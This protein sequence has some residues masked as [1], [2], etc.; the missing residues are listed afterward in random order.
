MKLHTLQLL[1]QKRFAD[2]IDALTK[3]IKADRYDAGL[4]Q[5]RSEAYFETGR[6]DLAV[7]DLRTANELSLHDPDYGD[8]Y[9]YQEYLATVLWI[10]GDRQEAIN[11]LYEKAEATLPKKV[12][13]V[14]MGGGVEPGLF[15]FY[16]SV[17][18]EAKRMDEYALNYVEKM[19]KRDPGV[20][21][22]PR[23]LAFF[24]LG[25]WS[26]SDLLRQQSEQAKSFDIK[27]DE[28]LSK[29]N[30]CDFLF[31]KATLARRA[32]DESA[33]QSLMK[34]CAALDVNKWW[35]EWLLARAETGLIGA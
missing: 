17:S 9:F 34:Q 20:M 1:E 3:E 26:E 4:H 8:K 11:A 29:Y 23:P 19:I 2:A 33:C 14:D 24:V 16:M 25:K 10:K 21:A 27:R 30:F 22:W 15:L 13:F 5:A 32:G 31:Y 6:L 12:K 18:A 35:N 7:A 28:P